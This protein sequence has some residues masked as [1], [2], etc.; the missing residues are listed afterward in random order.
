MCAK[1][2]SAAPPARKPKTFGRGPAWR[3]HRGD[4][5]GVIQK[6]PADGNF[7]RD[8]IVSARWVAQAI[9][10]NPSDYADLEAEG[11]DFA[12]LLESIGQDCARHAA[13]A[14]GFPGLWRARKG[15]VT[16]GD[17]MDLGD[18]FAAGR[19]TIDQLV[20]DLLAGRYADAPRDGDGFLI[21]D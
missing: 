10:Q 11:D 16:A 2:L 8:D 19:G 18:L 9:Q 13:M 7:L 5:D 15:R 1:R 17:V 4:R 21:L 6:A 14:L 20:A 12:A 3:D